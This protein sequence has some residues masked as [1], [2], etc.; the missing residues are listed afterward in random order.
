V[1]KNDFTFLRLILAKFQQSTQH[2]KKFQNLLDN[3]FPLKIWLLVGFFP[4]EILS[5]FENALW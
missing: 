5:F 1:I 3:F 2:F 4:F